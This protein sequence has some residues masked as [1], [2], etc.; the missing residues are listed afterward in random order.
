MYCAG[1]NIGALSV[2]AVALEGERREARV[3][4]HCGRPLEKLQEMLAQP[5]FAGVEYCGVSGQLAI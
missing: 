1:I 4:L 5:E 3:L 2:K